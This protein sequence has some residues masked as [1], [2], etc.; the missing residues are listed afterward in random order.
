MVGPMS[1]EGGQMDRPESEE[2]GLAKKLRPATFL[3]RS[4]PLDNC[5]FMKMIRRSH[6]VVVFEFSDV[7]YLR[8]S[9]CFHSER[10]YGPLPGCS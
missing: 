8:L 5:P 6:L 7:L 10:R 3:E 2:F 9:Y 4:K 1:R